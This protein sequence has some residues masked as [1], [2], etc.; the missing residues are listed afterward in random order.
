MRRQ[1]VARAVCVGLVAGM[2]VAV[3][4]VLSSA[5]GG[6]VPVAKA[7]GTPI[8]AISADGLY[9]LAGTLEPGMKAAVKKINAAGGVGG[10]PIEVVYC[11]ASSLNKAQACARQAA[12]DPT[13]VTAVGNLD[14]FGGFSAGA[15]AA[16]LPIV[17]A[18]VTASDFSSPVFFSPSVGALTVAGEAAIASDNLKAKHIVLAY[19]DVP[20]GAALPTLVNLAVLGPRGAKLSKS[21]P[22]PPDAVDLAPIVAAIPSDTDALLLAADA[23][24]L[25]KLMVQVRKAGLTFPIVT[26]TATQSAAQLKKTVGSAATNVYAASQYDILGAGYRRFLADMKASGYDKNSVEIND[27]A[28]TG[29]VLVELLKSTLD[30]VGPKNVTRESIL[31]QLRA[32]TSYEDGGLTPTVNWTQKQTALGGAVS[33]IVNAT[34]VAYKYDVKHSKY[35]PLDKGKFV[36]IFTS[37]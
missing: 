25:A 13:I 16:G 36:K 22:I 23:N 14:I 35:L 8:K 24:A 17:G 12:S 7:T 30:K 6:A 3:T 29:W 37:S 21:V 9:N 20:A 15:E 34:V 27:N 26:L 18:P 10:R 31:S 19:L 2:S 33:N 4:G 28:L 1:L 5:A 32:T 11:D